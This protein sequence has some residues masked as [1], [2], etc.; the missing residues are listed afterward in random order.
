[1][2]L[3]RTKCFGFNLGL[4]C[5][6][7]AYLWILL[8]SLTIIA[9]SSEYSKISTTPFSV[10]EVVVVDTVNSGCSTFRSEPRPAIRFFSGNLWG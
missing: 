5:L 9:S 10:I 8:K 6:C 2:E 4:Y 7:I 1:M 3:T